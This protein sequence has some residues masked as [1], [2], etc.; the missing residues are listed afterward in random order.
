VIE[1]NSDRK[2]MTVVVKAPNG[3]IKV[4]CKGSDAVLVPLLSDNW[5]N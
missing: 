4:L 2:R 5:E 1:F 3:E